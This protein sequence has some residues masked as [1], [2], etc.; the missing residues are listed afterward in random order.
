MALQV[1]QNIANVLIPEAQELR[2]S[3]E[4]DGVDALKEL[5][6]LQCAS[7]LARALDAQAPEDSTSWSGAS[8]YLEAKEIAESFLP[9]IHP[10]VSLTRSL[11]EDRQTSATPAPVT[12]PPL[13]PK[14]GRK[15]PTGGRGSPTKSSS[16]SSKPVALHEQ[17]SD[18]AGPSDRV[19]SPEQG[20]S[21]LSPGQAGS[22]E[23]S[24]K[25]NG[26]SPPGKEKSSGSPMQSMPSHE[27]SHATDFLQG[28]DHD[29][30]HE[31]DDDHYHDD[32]HA[33]RP[34]KNIFAEYLSDYQR[35]QEMT[36]PWF[37]NRQDE[38][39]KN[40]EEKARFVKLQ[41]KGK[42]L[43]DLAN[44]KFTSCG[45]KIQC[46]E[47]LKINVSRSEPALLQQVKKAGI[48][49]PEAYLT[50]KLRLVMDPSQKPM[51]STRRKKRY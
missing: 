9:P 25:S 3:G 2:A 17:K 40:M 32:D 51:Q 28:D 44:P 43:S 22:P 26:D 15:T 8:L 35:E 19:P 10:M 36:K 48:A 46:K 39:R 11:Y 42:N 29:H 31:H 16:S 5:R 30:D 23:K 20:S 14:S 49:S 21:K 47:L 38:L 50:S 45:H 27:D 13:S 41:D 6:V 24:E 18:S 12:L 4:I 37:F 33:P 34:P 7:L 1:Q